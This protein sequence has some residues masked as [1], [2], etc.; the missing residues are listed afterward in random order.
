[1]Q[2]LYPGANTKLY[3][4]ISCFGKTYCLILEAIFNKNKNPFR[5]ET[6]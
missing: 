3:N 6:L 2:F 5:L 4:D 1:M